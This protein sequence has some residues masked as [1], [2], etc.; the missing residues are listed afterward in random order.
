VGEHGGLIAVGDIS[1]DEAVDIVVTSEDT[2]EG[3]V[4]LNDGTCISRAAE[5]GDANADGT[6]NI[7]DPVAILAYLFASGSLRCPGVAEVNG[8]GRLNMADPVYILQH[9]FAQGPPLPSDGPYPC[10]LR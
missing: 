1:D 8:D 2:L 5:P 4:F 6:V 3:Q 10:A 9:L 7:A